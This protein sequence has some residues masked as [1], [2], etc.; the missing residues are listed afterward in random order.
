MLSFKEI[1]LENYLIRLKPL[2]EWSVR[3]RPA[4][5]L[6]LDSILLRAF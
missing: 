2:K 4:S 6:P 1:N 5:G 3:F